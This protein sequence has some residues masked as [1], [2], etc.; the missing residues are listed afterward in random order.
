MFYTGLFVRGSPAR[1]IID[2][3]GIAV[4][5]TTVVPDTLYQCQIDDQYFLL[6]LELESEELLREVELYQQFKLRPTLVKVGKFNIDDGTDGGVYFLYSGKWD[7]T[8]DNLLISNGIDL[9]TFDSVMFEQSAM[10]KFIAYLK[11]IETNGYIHSAL[12]PTN[13]LVERH[14]TSGRVTKFGVVDYSKFIQEDDFDYIA[15][16]MVAN[17]VRSFQTSWIAWI[18]AV[19]AKPPMHRIM[20]N[21]LEK[22]GAVLSIE[23]QVL[24]LILPGNVL[25]MSPKRMTLTQHELELKQYKRKVKQLH[26]ATTKSR[27]RGLRS[28]QIELEKLKQTETMRVNSVI[29]AQRVKWK[30]ALKELE[31]EQKE[32]PIMPLPM[33]REIPNI[34]IKETLI[35]EGWKE[36]YLQKKKET[37]RN[38]IKREKVEQPKPQTTSLFATARSVDDGPKQIDTDTNI[39]KETPWVFRRWVNEV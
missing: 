28:I 39:G 24:Q 32:Q 25:D 17:T 3:V 11:R 31:R 7:T 27:E 10:N 36:T 22:L 23:P 5:H 26:E 18:I 20:S 9:S 34:D 2:E 12:F 1:I 13:I 6:R 14:P 15:F 37:I 4:I 30:T 29:R 16:E 21:V 38:E 8:L 35:Q 33:L 19:G